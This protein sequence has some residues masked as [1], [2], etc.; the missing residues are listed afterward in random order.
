MT[1][2][3]QIQDP[4]KVKPT[5]KALIKSWL[6]AGN[7]ITQ[8][9][10]SQMTTLGSRLAPRILN[11]REDGFPILDQ[12]RGKKSADGADKHACYYLPKYFLTQVATAG[13]ETALRGEL[14]ARQAKNTGAKV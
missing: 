6:L 4:N 14:L 3:K 10:F 11:L 13:L 8:A 9:Q 5:H 1:K 2:L 7:S 12:N